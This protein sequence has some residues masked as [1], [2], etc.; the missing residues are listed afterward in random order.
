M[1]KASTK[2]PETG[3]QVRKEMGRDGNWGAS[4]GSAIHRNYSFEHVTDPDAEVSSFIQWKFWLGSPWDNSSFHTLTA[5][6]PNS[7]C[8][9]LYGPQLFSLL[10][11][12]DMCAQSSALQR[13]WPS[14]SPSSSFR[15]AYSFLMIPSYACV[16][17][18]MLSCDW[19]LATP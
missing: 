5:H 9:S 14:A 19:L 16:H 11:T 1:E 6:Q 7:C 8:L 12:E 13:P 3:L 10:P 18:C 17:A 4:F 2:H 15:K